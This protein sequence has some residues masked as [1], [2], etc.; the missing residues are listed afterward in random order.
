M[1]P[2]KKGD[3]NSESYTLCLPNNVHEIENTLET[4]SL[5]CMCLYLQLLRFQIHLQRG[6][7]Q[8]KRTM[9]CFLKLDKKQAL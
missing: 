4:E 9:L 7:S 1:L 2:C 5:M 8:L 3:W 6:F